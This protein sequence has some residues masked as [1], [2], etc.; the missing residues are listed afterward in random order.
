MET[1]SRWMCRI[2]HL[3][4]KLLKGTAKRHRGIH[5]RSENKE[6]EGREGKESET[7]VWEESNGK[8]RDGGRTHTFMSMGRNG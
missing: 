3:K 7:E 1:E 8:G 6:I 2:R 5:K 4:G